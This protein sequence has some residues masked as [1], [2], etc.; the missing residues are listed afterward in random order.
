MGYFMKQTPLMYAC[1]M[2]YIQYHPHTPC[3]TS[4]KNENI[5]FLF[6]HWIYTYLNQ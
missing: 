1:N 6:C 5:Q 2:K 3:Q 4:D